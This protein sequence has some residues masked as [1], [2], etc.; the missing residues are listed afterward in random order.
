MLYDKVYSSS[1]YFDYNDMTDFIRI[2]KIL[3]NSFDGIINITYDKYPAILLPN[4]YFQEDY[5]FIETID[6]IEKSIKRLAFDFYQPT[7]YIKNKIWIEDYTKPTYKNISYID[8]NRMITDTNLL[9]AHRT[10]TIS[11]YNLYTNEEWNTGVTSLE[12]EE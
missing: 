9:Y 11:I 8:I 6:E 10:D 12:W 5:L 1:D 7:G 4:D 2:L 3:L